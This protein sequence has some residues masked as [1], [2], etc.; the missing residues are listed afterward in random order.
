MTVTMDAHV[1]AEE[2]FGQCDLKDKRR[3][4]RLVHMAANALAHPSGSLPEQ[5]TDAADLKAA[6]RLFG[7]EDVTFEDIAGPHWAQTRRRPPGVYLVLNDTTEVDFGIRRK[8]RGHGA[9]R[10]RRRLGISAAFGI[11]GRRGRRSDLRPGGPEDSLSQAGPEKGKLDAASETRPRV[12]A[13]GAGHRSGRSAGGR[14]AMGA[15]DGPRSRQLRGVL[16]LSTTA[17]GLGGAR[18]T[19]ATRRDRARRTNHDFE[20]DTC[21]HC[22]AEGSTSCICGHGRHNPNA[23]I[24]RHGRRSR[25]ARQKWRF[26]LGHCGCRFPGKRVPI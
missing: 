2:Q 21:R 24:N 5:T 25:P 1:W 7:C 20:C 17:G 4:Q 6:Y 18:H 26:V 23:A 13:V 19:E 12:G 22:R 10:Q 16:P 11:V 9:D 3:T 8:V 14:S 15:C